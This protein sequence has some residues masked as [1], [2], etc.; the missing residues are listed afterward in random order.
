MNKFLLL[1]LL[2]AVILPSVLFLLNPYTTT[3]QRHWAVIPCE[4]KVKYLLGH[5][6][7]ADNMA[8][9]KQVLHRLRQALV[10][11]NHVA[12]EGNTGDAGA[13]M[14]QQLYLEL[15]QIPCVHQVCE[16]G[17]NAGHSTTVWVSAANNISVLSF[18]IAQY[19]YTYTAMRFYAHNYPGRVVFVLGSSTETLPKLSQSYAGSCNMLVVDGGHDYEVAK[20]DILNMRVL[21]NPDFSILIVDDT[22]CSA[23][24]CQGPNQAVNELEQAG[25][26]VV[27]QRY[28]LSFSRGFTVGKY[29]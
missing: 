27:L 20:Q 15:A 9:Q 22:P 6:G 12:F 4:N 25:I 29:L 28:P 10:D 7:L 19:D 13:E 5:E 24:W 1:L 23:E 21:A 3:N 16:I 18:D 11:A 8:Q 26:I 17:F 14:Q 2:A